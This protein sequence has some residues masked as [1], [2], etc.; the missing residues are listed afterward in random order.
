M[1]ASS[2]K[3][4]LPWAQPQQVAPV[5]AAAARQGGPIVYAPAFWRLIMLIIRHRRLRF[6]QAHI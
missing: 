3:K 5:V 4:G 1:T 2:T 6:Q